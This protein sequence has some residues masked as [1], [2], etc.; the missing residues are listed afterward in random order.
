MTFYKKLS[1]HDGRAG[2]L[3][4]RLL[5]FQQDYEGEESEGEDEG[6]DDVEDDD[7]PGSQTSDTGENLVEAAGEL[8]LDGDTADG[9]GQSVEQV[10]GEGSQQEV[11]LGYHYA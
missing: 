11:R 5:H 2:G 4:L 7:G 3:S 1:K 6:K 10:T 8:S 9:D